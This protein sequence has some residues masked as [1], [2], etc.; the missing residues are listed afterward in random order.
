MLHQPLHTRA[1]RQPFGYGVHAKDSIMAKVRAKQ[2]AA[3]RTE[4][5]AQASAAERAKS[6]A[7][8]QAKLANAAKGAEASPA[9]SAKARGSKGG[10]RQVA[11]TKGGGE[12]SGQVKAKAAVKTETNKKA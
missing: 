7:A 3:S 8:A 2:L 11:V 10:G 12:G 6:T 9:E 5:A 1:S 4:R